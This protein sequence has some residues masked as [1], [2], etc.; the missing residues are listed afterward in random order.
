MEKSVKLLLFIKIVTFILLCWICYFYSVVFNKH[1]DESYKLLGEKDIRSYR[2]L[3][4]FKQNHVSSII[5]LKH[6]IPNNEL[7]DKKITCN[8]EKGNK[9]IYEH[10]HGNS[11]DNIGFNKLAKNNKSYIFETKKYS[12][13]EK[14]IFK[15]LDYFDFLTNNRIITNRTYKKITCKKYALRLAL[16]LLGFLF[17]VIALILDYGFNCGL[18]KGLFKLLLFSLGRTPLDRFYGYLRDSPVFSFIKNTVGKTGET[19]DLY[20]R[21]F[22]NIVI[23]FT[24]FV[25]LGI[26]IILGIVYYH[27]KVKKYE[28]IKYKKR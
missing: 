26:T 11:L 3:A 8:N 1:L 7:K 15:E 27:R 20:I 12:H 22:L 6:V 10:L 28:K 18:R 24:S 23:Y 25:I 19:K 17:L 14:K 21:P 13:L 2:L 4:K 16:P 5:G 9:V